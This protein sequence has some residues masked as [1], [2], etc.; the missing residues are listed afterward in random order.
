MLC[1]DCGTNNPDTSRFCSSCGAA[2]TRTAPPEPAPPQTPPIQPPEQP[3]P[4]PPQPEGEGP[5]QAPSDQAPPEPPPI[6]SPEPPAP[7]PEGPPSPAVTIARMGDRL[8]ALILDSILIIAAF[9]VSG[10]WAAA[11][12]GGVTKH[13]FSLV[14]TPAVIAFLATTL[15]GIFYHWLMEGLFGATLGKMILGI[16]I[17]AVSGQRCGMKRALIRTL[18]RIIDGLFF[19]LVGFV[20][21]LC[22]KQR[23]RIGDH[24][25]KTVVVEKQG[26]KGLRVVFAV[27]WLVL[28]GGGIVFAWFLHRNA[29]PSSA[30]ASDGLKVAKFEFLEKRDGAVRASAVYRPGDKL[31]TRYTL[32]GYETDDQ[33]RVNLRITIAV[34]DPN[35][36]TVAQWQGNLNR[37]LAD[38]ESAQGWFN[39]TLLPYVPPGTYRIRMTVRDDAR[40]KVAEQITVFTVDAPQPVFSSS[41]DL[42][43][44]QLSL[45]DGGPPVT[46]AV[47]PGTTVYLNAKIAGMQFSADRVQV[48]VAFQLI[49]PQG[50]VLIDKP[51]FIMLNESV[52]YHPPGFYVPLSSTVNL[53]STG[54]MGTY[55]Q[56]YEV[57]DLV[58]NAS[59]TFTQKVDVQ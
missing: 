26:G 19:Y 33:G 3:V 44:M 46:G 2:L 8:L 57:T 24:A 59:A 23:Q 27:L 39:F 41:L 49:D 29:P 16:R 48:R 12:W 10:M 7:G 13:G 15:F 17:T 20:V 32:S 52:E 28:V 6:L 47:S 22:S 54:P 9:V 45:S 58:A 55:T 30:V 34:T 38:D 43:D 35:S 50:E 18:L 51:D 36:L 40:N 11:T 1:P 37:K 31:F 4:P 21:A 56:K 42:R 14:G 5:A 53:P 25:A